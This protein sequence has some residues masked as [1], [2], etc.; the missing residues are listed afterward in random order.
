MVI[1]VVNQFGIFALKAKCQAPVAIYPYRPVAEKFSTQLV[2]APIWDIH[3]F[4]PGCV[5]Q[6]G[7]LELQPCR[8]MG[9]YAFLA[10]CSEKSLKPFMPERF[11]HDALLT[12]KYRLSM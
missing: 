5:V 6:D 7:K 11:D 4:R 10:A 9:L 3:I 1:L 12:V 2:Q 8:V